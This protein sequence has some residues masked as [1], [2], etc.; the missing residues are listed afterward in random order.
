MKYFNMILKST[1]ETVHSSDF[2]LVSAICLY[3]CLLDQACCDHSGAWDLSV[4]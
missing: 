2:E 4:L 1:S 3:L